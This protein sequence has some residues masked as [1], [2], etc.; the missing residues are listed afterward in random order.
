MGATTLVSR[1]AVV[2]GL[3]AAAA[4]ALWPHPVSAA[5]LKWVWTGGITPDSAV[6]KAAVGARETVSLVVTT[7]GGFSRR[8][9]SVADD[10]GVAT[11]KISGLAPAAAHAYTVEAA[12]RALQGRFST[13]GPGP[14]SFRLAFASCASTGSNSA[15]FDAIRYANPLMFLHMGDLHY[16]NIARNDE[17]EFG[18][19]FDKVH[20]ARRQAQLYRA[21]PIVYMW[22]DH[23]YGPNDSD[24]DSPSR[25]AALAAYRRFVP[26]YPLVSATGSIQQAFSIGRV[27]VVVLD[28]RSARAPRGSLEPR[29]MIGCDQLAWLD[30]ELET[31]RAS[32]LLLL[33]NSVP[34]ITKADESTSEGWAP[35]AQ[36]REHIAN[37]IER[38]GLTRRTLMLSGDA[39]QLALDDGTHSQYST[40]AQ[41]SRL[42]FPVLHAA[43]MDRS[44]T[45]KGGPYSHGELRQN[46]QFGVLDIGDAGEALQIRFQAHRRSGP[47]PN[48][49][50]AWTC[51]AQGLVRSDLR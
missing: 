34:W 11:F 46:G 37:A 25:P 47:A 30:R 38:A 20:G 26:H 8:L 27:R 50:M 10:L 35:Y 28:T 18:R 36:E 31:A 17:A 49:R 24:R 44:N 48:M 51:G 3:A 16:E 7:E 33:V 19:A 9:E 12:G 4:G 41:A 6:L 45:Q 15:V 43:P 2:T 40:L 21:V 23:D 29:T 14:F 22:D 5:G 42:G 39:H 13:P 1:R 32:A